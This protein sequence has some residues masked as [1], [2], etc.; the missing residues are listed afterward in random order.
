MKKDQIKKKAGFEEENLDSNDK[1]KIVVPK[2]K[3]SKTEKLKSNRKDSSIPKDVANRMARRIAITT[4]LP[5]FM[6]MGVFIGSYIVVSRGIADIA[7]GITLISSAG[8]FLIGLLGLSYGILSASWEE[9]NGSILGFENI[10][11]NIIRM[12]SAFQSLNKEK[13]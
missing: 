6:G 2:I 4:G 7:P 11:P 3:K 8:C 5:T 1:K 9:T 10:G 12:K 13:S